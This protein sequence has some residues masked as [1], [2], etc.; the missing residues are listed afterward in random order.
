MTENVEQ[1]GAGDG[2]EPA[3]P[4][5]EQPTAPPA[6]TPPQWAVSRIDTLTRQMRERE[7]Q[8]RAAE[9]ELGRL[10]A[11]AAPAAP[12]APSQVSIEDQVTLRAQQLA[13]EQEF[14]RQTLELDRRGAQEFPDWN[15]Q[16]AAFQPL[17]AL[18]RTVVEAAL[19]LDDP[20]RVIH[21][22]S[23][24]LN[25]AAQIFSMSP[26]RQAAALAKYGAKLAAPPAPAPRVSNAPAPVLPVVGGGAKGEPDVYDPGIP[27]GEFMRLRAAQEKARRAR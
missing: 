19:E 25:T 26:V 21:A 27:L 4:P 1:P 2:Q 6:P 17:G 7:E 13:V 22:L 14:R 18:P 23:R 12:P 15:Q 11:A 10:R 9:A 24:D 5:V 8:L 3:V 16:I 20:H